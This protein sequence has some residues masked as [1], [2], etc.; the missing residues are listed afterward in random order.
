MKKAR[1]LLVL[2][3]VLWMTMGVSCNTSYKK[4][5]TVEHDFTTAL[6]AFHQSRLSLQQQGLISDAEN[7]QLEG[8]EK[9]ILLAD[10]TA[11]KS[12]QASVNA[13]T[14]Q[15]QVQVIVDTIGDL[16]TNGLT[17][18]KNPTSVQILKT[19]LLAADAIAQNFL[20]ALKGSAT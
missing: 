14:A 1:T 15:A 2:P 7:A 19:A 3:L 6:Q 16:Q 20:T 4:A 10:Q 17:G 8:Y 18:I 5:V 12:M 13:T 9:K 11:V